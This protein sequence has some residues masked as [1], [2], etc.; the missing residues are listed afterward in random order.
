MALWKIRICF[1]NS[2]KMHKLIGSR[3]WKVKKTFEIPVFQLPFFVY[4]CW[5]TIDCKINRLSFFNFMKKK[6]LLF[7]K[8][9]TI[10]LKK[11]KGVTPWLPLLMTSPLAQMWSNGNQFLSKTNQVYNLGIVRNIKT[12]VQY[13]IILK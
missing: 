12:Q 10:T 5:K 1:K 6:Y 9:S 7:R 4:D 2:H 13:V 11:A 3:K 8:D